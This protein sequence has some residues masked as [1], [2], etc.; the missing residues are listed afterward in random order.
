MARQE[1]VRPCS[2]SRLSPPTIFWFP[3]CLQSKQVANEGTSGGDVTVLEQESPPYP[4]QRLLKAFA[5]PREVRNVLFLPY[6][7]PDLK[8]TLTHNPFHIGLSSDI[9]IFIFR[10]YN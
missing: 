7:Q 5:L 3:G 4:G 8:H 9:I 2:L 1:D 6:K 10:K